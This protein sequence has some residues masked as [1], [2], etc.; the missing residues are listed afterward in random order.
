MQRNH[1][2]TFLLFAIFWLTSLTACTQSPVSYVPLERVAVVP[3]KLNEVS[4]IANARKGYCYMHNDGGNK[5]ELYEITMATG[6]IVKKIEIDNAKNKDW[7]EL[8]EDEDAIY[9]GDFGNNTGNRDDLRILIV[10]RKD[11]EKDDKVKTDKIHFTYPDQKSF[12]S[13]RAHDYDCEAMIT[14]GDALYLFS[15]NRESKTTDVYRLPKEPGEYVAEKIAHFD[16]DGLVTAADVWHGKKRNALA[17]LCYEPIGR[18]YI[19]YMWLF[20]DF[21]P[22]NVFGGKAHRLDI[23]PNLQAEAILW[24]SD[25]TVIIINEEQWAG[26]GQLSRLDLSAYLK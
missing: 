19:S 14:Y 16:T 6:E 23:S 18:R 13:R 26:Q 11:L 8:A 12:K 5:A 7:E 4:G 25:T 9:I 15:K 20:T 2:T 1:P 21:E 24:E 3:G 22:T 10:D 17:L